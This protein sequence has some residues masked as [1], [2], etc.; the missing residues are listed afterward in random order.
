M[1]WGLITHSRKNQL[2]TETE[3]IQ[4]SINI[5]DAT[6]ALSSR[7]T[8]LGQSRKEDQKPTASIVNPKNKTRIGNWN[9]RT[10]FETGKAG[11]VAREMKRYKLDI[12][13]ISEC[14]WRG[15]GKSKLNTGEVI[16]YSG[17]ENIHQGGVAIMMSQQAAR[18]LMEWTPE[19]SRI[20]RA[21]FYSKY[22]KLTLIHAYSP[23]NDASIESKDDF[24]EQLEGTVQKCN[25]NDILLIT[26]DLNAKVGKGTPLEE[27][28]VLGQHGTGDRN[29]NGERLCEFCEM[30]GLV[31]TGTIFPHKEIHKA[32]WTSPNGRTKN[33]IDHTMI[34][35][36]Y[37]SSIMDT[38]VRRGADVGSDHYLVE[39]RLKLKLKRSPREMKG[40]TRLDM[41]KLADE[42]MLVKYNIEVRNRFQALTELE[43]E[44]ENADHLN[45]R[46]ENIY[47]GA[48]KDVLGIAKRAC[49]PWLRGGT[50]KKVEK[51]R[52]LKLKL[53]STSSERVKRRI[54]EQYKGKDQ[55]VKRS[56]REDKRYW[57]NEMANTAERAAENGRA[58]E[59]H[60][61]VKTLTGEKKRTSTVVNDKNGKPTN[62]RSERLKI[63]KEHFDTVLNK[64]PPVRPIQPHEIE[65]MQKDR[66]FDIRAFQQTLLKM[67]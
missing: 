24:Y 7:M 20:I 12:L 18:C 34:A 57:M 44:E 46:M 52:Q 9:V 19:S 28:E 37:R 6:R 13:G 22:R 49:K 64:E 32:T 60:R 16:I 36:E 33:Q 62:E 54:K 40:R 27:R 63:W 25:R 14:R 11:Q 17:E 43:E 66:E 61:I 48:A 23:T 50:W 38:V 8:L 67:Q 30:N 41:Q 26:G 51:R 58:G 5:G 21:R 56:A 29:E 59:L 3:D 1:G 31:I 35:K 45:N 53:E 15:S 39:T 65:T 47:V 4:S 10:M 2:I 42:E 55:E